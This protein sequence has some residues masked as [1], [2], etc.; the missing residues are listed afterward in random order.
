MPEPEPIPTIKTPWGTLTPTGG[1]PTG[2]GES[3]PVAVPDHTLLRR[4]GRG[5]YGEVWLARNALGLYRAVKVL[6]RSSFGDDR[7]FERE[8]AGIQRFEPISRSHESQLNILHVGRTAEHF[9]YVMELADDQGRGPAIDE[10]TYAARTLRSEL[11]FRGR[12]PVDEC[13]RLGLALSTALEHLHRHGLVHRDIKPSNIV[14]V[15]GIPKLADIGLVALAER[16]MSFVGTEGYLPPEGPGTVQADLF[17]LGKVLYE[18]STGNDRQQFPEL[19]TNVAELPDRAALAEFNEVLVRACAPDVKERYRT[20]AE[21]HADLALLQSGGSVARARSVERRLKF[22]ARGG[23]LVA[24]LAVLAGLAFLYQQSQTREA[25]RL[26]EDNRDLAAEKLKLAERAEASA[27]LARKSEATARESLYAA[28]IQLAQQALQADNL[29]LARSLLQNHVPQPGQP[30]LRGFEW[31]YLWHQC[32][33]EELFSFKG[34]TNDSRVLAFAP[35]GKHLAVGGY[36]GG[37]IRL[38]D[39]RLRQPVALLPDTNAILS[40]SFS[41]KGEILASGSANDV[42]LWDARSFQE[43]RRLT[44]AVAPAVFS[45]DG[46][47]LLTGRGPWK[48]DEPD[49]DQPKEVLVWDTGTWT[50]LHT[51]TFPVSGVPSGSRDLFLQLAFGSDSGR[52]AMLTGG[53]VRLVSC[54]E[55]KE[56]LVLPEKLPE[57][58]TSRPFIALSPDNRILALPSP[59]GYGVRLWDT[60]ENRELRVLQ[61]HADHIFSARFSPDG[62]WLATTSP[63]QT[64]KL[65]EVATGKLLHTFRGQADEVVDVAFSPDGT[66]LAS[67]GI[68]ESVVLVWDPRAGRR[69][70][71]IPLWPQGFDAGG[72]FVAFGPKPERQLVAVDP[73]NLKLVPIAVPKIQ[74]GVSYANKLNSLSADGRYHA[75][76]RYQEKLLEVWDRRLGTR[77]CSVPN[78]SPSISFDLR[79]QLVTTATT[80][81]VGQLVL[82]A[83]QLPAGNLKWQVDDFTGAGIMTTAQGDYVATVV[84]PETHIARIEDDEFKPV[85]KVGTR[86]VRVAVS[87]D[88]RLL[89]SGSGD[90]TLKSLPE[91][92]VIGVLEGHTRKTV[93][94][95]FSPDSR[96]LASIA[97]DH[98]A[99][100][101][102][103]ATQRELL[104]FQAPT[105]DHDL[106]QVEFS[107]DGRALALYRHDGKNPATSLY[108]AP[109]LAEIAA[110]EGGDYRALAGEHAP[111]WLAVSQ[112]LLRGGK[113]EAAL[114]A[115]SRADELAETRDEVGWWLRPMIQPHRAELL[116]RMGRI[117]EAGRENL[118]LLKIPARDPATPAGAID[119]SAYYTA[120]LAWTRDPEGAANDLRE[121]PVGHQVFDGTH[122]DVRGGLLI[123]GRSAEAEWQTEPARADGIR[124][125][126]RLTRLHFLQ[127]AHAESRTTK[128]GDRIGHY[129]IHFADGRSVELPI[130]YN[131]D[132][133]DYWELDHLPREVPEA[134]LA[135]RGQ[136]PR[137]RA[138]GRFIRLFKRTWQNPFPEVEVT[139]LDFIAEHPWTHPFLVA[140]T[141]D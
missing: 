136:N 46:R 121:L 132:T 26:A 91:G 15:N 65:W 22:L 114:A 66:R 25:R 135:W 107:P 106:F 13:L 112:E 81:A 109:S 131:V 58:L 88:G 82:N 84:G 96:T 89:A 68:T 116:R 33:S 19:P 72:R 111:T 108:F 21:L 117:D 49:W 102:H 78:L 104:R 130:R 35:G 54:P 4:I 127:M 133:S 92:K 124:I 53:T 47:F 39:L 14:F 83:W 55:L 98:T 141:A 16:T 74:A 31:R 27:G 63:D 80:N 48:P 52:V 119:L 87:P 29:R 85:L 101:W 100:V 76:F 44:N 139:H 59:K 67:L 134:T 90:I 97:D 60:V 56:L 28:D 7:P 105:E 17:S 12:L 138:D 103:L 61:G 6:H 128:T 51:A 36:A 71:V 38:L 118:G 129:R 5:A 41:P 137:S 126:R 122:F 9:Y 2:P 1:A 50:V 45:P 40:L 99:R 20:A 125:Q 70:E 123:V 42:R 95:A 34:Q 64:V 8:F 18:I 3:P 57:S 120:T 113:L 37:N 110:A 86:Y 11:L 77:L 140:L 24:G 115:C 30:D 62:T 10:T 69:S 79:R 75:L 32:R 93:L 23:A 73:A 94:P 43:V